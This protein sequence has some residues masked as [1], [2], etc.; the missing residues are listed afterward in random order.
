VSAADPAWYSQ[1]QFFNFFN[2]HLFQYDPDITL[3]PF[4]G[5]AWGFDFDVYPAISADNPL[6]Q[7]E[8]ATWKS[9]N[10]VYFATISLETVYF[11]QGDG[12]DPAWDAFRIIW[13]N[14]IRESGPLPITRFPVPSFRI[15]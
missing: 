7:Q 6:P 13:T 10:G 14:M 4:T 15:S 2:G 12:P 9:T 5:E 3:I 1:P 11:N 8:V